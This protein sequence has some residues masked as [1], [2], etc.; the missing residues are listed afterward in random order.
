MKEIQHLFEAAQQGDA[1]SVRL[2]LANGISPDS[3]N[4]K[5]YSL[6]SESVK[7]PEIVQLLIDAGA[8]VNLLDASGLAPIH[9]CVDYNT[10]DTV[11]ILLRAGADMYVETAYQENAGILAA[12]CSAG[13]LKMMKKLLACGYDINHR[14]TTGKTMLMTSL[15]DNW[16][17]GTR[18]LLA[19]GAKT[20]VRDNEGDTALFYGC[21]TNIYCSTESLDALLEAG[22]DI[23]ATNNLGNNALQAIADLPLAE[24]RT[25][26]YLI[27]HGIDLHHRNK[28]GQTAFD[29]AKAHDNKSLMQLLISHEAD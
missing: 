3:Q 2:F 24:E 4:E 18:W 13:S 21:S 29:L 19:H 26:E 23:N 5:G 12:N 7:H 27:E 11:E 28:D 25:H 16:E 6:L 8:D 9:T 1:A 17:T 15:G 10:P 14:S 20:E 22:A